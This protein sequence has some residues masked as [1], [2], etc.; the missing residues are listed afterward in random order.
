M[1]ELA[2]YELREPIGGDTLTETVQAR[3]IQDGTLVLM[4]HPRAERPDTA[5]MSLLRHEFEVCSQFDSNRIIK[6]RQLGKYSGGYVLVYEHF[7]AM[8]LRGFL[9]TRKLSLDMFFTVA[10]G[11][12]EAI[13]QVH[14]RKITH[15]NISS[16]SIL[17]HPDTLQSK[18]TDFH[19]A[20]MLESESN[21]QWTPGARAWSL[22]YI[23]PEQTGRMNRPID[24]R[25]DFYSLGAV[26]Y[27][28][29]VGWLPFQSD[30]QMEMVHAHIAKMP[31]RPH[32]LNPAIPAMLSAIVMKLLE[33]NAETRYQ[34][35]EGILADV[36]ECMHH[37][38]TSLSVPP[39]QLGGNESFERFLVPQK[40]YGRNRE[41]AILKDAFDAVRQGETRLVV[42]AGYS[43]IGKTT[44]VHELHPQITRQGG[45]Y[46]SGKFEMLLRNIPY[47][48]MIQAFEQF[49]RYLLSLDEHAL[50]RWRGRI[51]G[52]L[53]SNAKII[54]ELVPELGLVLGPQPDLVALPSKESE[55]RSR[56]ALLAFTQA[57]ADAEHPL[58]LF[59]DDWQWSDT[60]SI[61]FI[62]QLCSH[63]DTSHILLVCAYRE[64][65][66]DPGHPLREALAAIEKSRTRT[67]NIMLQP[68]KLTHVVSIV[69]D[70]LHITS[71]EE[72]DLGIMIHKKTEGNPFFVGE[73]IRSLYAKNLLRYNRAENR[74]SWNIE[75]IV[76]ENITDNVAE[77]M[78][79]RIH[80]MPGSTQ[81]VLQLASCIG[82]RF[83]LSTLATINEDS[84]AHT[85]QQLWASIQ[86]GLILPVDETYRMYQFDESDE[87]PVDQLSYHVRGT[88]YKFLHDRVQQAA[89]ALIPA[90]EHKPV[91]LH[92]GRLLL[93]RTKRGKSE[94]SIFDIVYHFNLSLDLITVQQE[95]KDV[96]RMNLTAGRLARASGSYETAYG[97]CRNGFTLLSSLESR[98]QLPLYAELVHEL[99]ICEYLTSRHG[100]AEA[101]FDEAIEIEPDNIRKT[102]ILCSKIMVYTHVSR[103]QD[104]L[105]A[106]SQGL[107]LLGYSMNPKPGKIHVGRKVALILFRLRG[108]EI[109][110]MASLPLMTDN[111]AIMA[112]DLLVSLITVAY[113][114]SNEM[115][116]LLII[117][118]MEIVLARG[119]TDSSAFVFGQFSA[120]LGAG[121]GKYQQAVEYGL[122]AAELAERFPHPLWNG[123]VQLTLGVFAY[124]WH[125]PARDMLPLLQNASKMALQSGDYLYGIWIN[126]YKVS[127]HF[128]IGE[129]LAEVKALVES[130]QRF[131]DQINYSELSLRVF[132]LFCSEMML[133]E[134]SAVL[135]ETLQGQR[136]ALEKDV[137][138]DK[139]NTS[140][141]FHRTNRLLAS[142]L[143]G[144]HIEAEALVNAPKEELQGSFGQMLE[145]QYYFA[146]SLLLCAMHRVKPGQRK[147]IT[148]QLARQ[149][150]KLHRWTRQYPA[151]YQHLADLIDAELADVKNDRVAAMQ[152]Y[153]A[154]I[155]SANLFG[156]PLYIALANECAGLFYSRHGQQN[157]ALFHLRDAHHAYRRWGATQK[158]LLM[159]RDFPE[160]IQPAPELPMH[161]ELGGGA[162]GDRSFSTHLDAM[163]IVKAS[164]AFSSEIVLDRLLRKLIVLML[165]N[166]GAERG[167]LLLESDGALLV[168]A[169]GRSENKDIVVRQGIPLESCEHISHS[170]V[171]FVERT[172]R[173]V[174]LDAA[175]RQGDFTR[176]VHIASEAVVSVLCLP[177]L[178]S[179]KLSGI[180]Y[181][182]NNLIEG[183]FT[184]ERI[185]VLNILTAEMAIAI[186]NARLY[187]HLDSAKREI[188]EYNRTLEQKVEDRTSDL[189]EKSEELQRTIEH[190]HTAQEQLIHAEKL[191]SLGQLTAG[192]AH[193][194]KNPLNFVNNF[195]ALSRE[196]ADELL[197]LFLH[198]NPF[199]DEHNR[200]DI[201][202]LVEG[203]RL[204]AEKISEHGTRADAIVRSM[205]MHA[206]TDPGEK[207]GTNINVLLNDSVDLA[208]HGLHALDQSCDVEIVKDYDPAEPSLLVSPQEIAQVFRNLLNNA[209]YAVNEKWRHIPA[210][211][212]PRDVTPNADVPT[213][214]ITAERPVVRVSTR[215]VPTG[216]EIRI[217]DNGPGIPENIM[218]DIFQPFFTT[219]PTGEGTGLGLSMS[220]DIITKG[221]GGSIA[222]ESTPGEGTVFIVT[223][224][225]PT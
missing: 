110:Q 107:R 167:F 118:M 95:K 214:G 156:A 26:L 34:S 183:A 64:N 123:R 142:I 69:S 6:V 5:T 137:R 78:T 218:S 105:T 30:D 224:P 144:E 104:A 116:A 151:N 108:K 13:G 38:Q 51:L 54:I 11:I 155:S 211:G 192:I 41:I 145:T 179:S 66:V 73:F 121:L 187:A 126:R 109:R 182:E 12:V 159:E 56:S 133:D 176:D 195:A 103:F 147:A 174:V 131:A 140:R 62:Q 134:D 100:E 217:E 1:R 210:P 207:Q 124:K 164:R 215:L 148:R 115:Y 136:K 2:G 212:T 46:L 163:T 21:Q 22:A 203:L 83:A 24:Y 223:L 169:E 65:E 130:A 98:R 222:V 150:K 53:G 135:R 16:G 112:I 18:L 153:D 55:T 117:T 129:P 14:R 200:A 44:L 3:N 191:A 209:M 9:A 10:I 101:H 81:R 77:L 68:L 122:L 149:Q 177:L 57:M 28:M 206:Q 33:K 39:F 219:K 196:L 29:L 8:T 197:I 97:Y 52:A 58:V 160:L 88:E 139:D 4:K 171:R 50:E 128:F 27:E 132:D 225:K 87:I 40:M 19:I 188:E 120:I 17:I 114:H 102:A 213:T 178:F 190:L 36:Q 80:T 45:Q 173:P 91:H 158:V 111:G 180:V 75:E 220:Y 138:E 204:N 119:V 201:K 43:G 185:D 106:G 166:A 113:F 143:L 84:L 165:E 168:E 181:L 35:H 194:I 199:D 67:G 99:G 193:E 47:Y 205:M 72:A 7:N 189:R 175:F 79:S 154:A 61:E 161:M 25:T 221:H 31:A 208:Y 48:A 96:A 15:N 89:Y 37:W 216:L 42:I 32:E 186:E 202:E 146:S 125:R 74:W 49:V 127:T 93:N 157:I 184:P 141:M 59:F 23:S 90:E 76:R 70:T 63:P 198:D 85:A 162:E 82:N 94:D 86:S 170:V 172:Q 152:R 71:G 20:S 60:A 92:I